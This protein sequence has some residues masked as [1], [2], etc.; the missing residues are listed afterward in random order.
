MSTCPQPPLCRFSCTAG[1]DRNMDS[2][3]YSDYTFIYYIYWIIVKEIY[4]IQLNRWYM[5]LWYDPRPRPWFTGRSWGSSGTAQIM[6]ELRGAPRD[7]RWSLGWCVRLWTKGMVHTCWSWQYVRLCLCI[8]MVKVKRSC[9][10]WMVM[11]AAEWGEMNFPTQ[12]LVSVFFRI[13]DKG[14]GY[15]AIA[16]HTCMH[17]HVDLCIDSYRKIYR[18]TII[19][20]YNTIYDIYIYILYMYIMFYLEP[21]NGPKGING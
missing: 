1:K 11:E 14:T 16:I 6:A 2:H 8:P 13:F 4:M 9:F 7:Q 17:A 5:D 20:C 10:F 3:G 21:S 12:T 15:W 18:Y 19:Y